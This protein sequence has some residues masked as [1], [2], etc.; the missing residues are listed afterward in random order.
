M[1]QP[2][3]RA[4]VRP[5]GVRAGGAHVRVHPLRERQCTSHE[6]CASREQTVFQGKN[7]LMIMIILAIGTQVDSDLYW[8]TKT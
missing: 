2:V 7:N 5:G 3:P 1:E 6:V 4:S 8:Y